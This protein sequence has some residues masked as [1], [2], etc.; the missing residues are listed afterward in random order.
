MPSFSK[1][2]LIFLTFDFCVTKTDD[3]Q[4]FGFRDFINIDYAKLDNNVNKI[5]WLSV[6][7]IIPTY[8]LMQYLQ[9]CLVNLF[10]THFPIKTMIKRDY[11]NI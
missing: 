1:L 7:D 11:D 5:E 9:D 10:N 3:V 8:D 2:D 6:K 4:H